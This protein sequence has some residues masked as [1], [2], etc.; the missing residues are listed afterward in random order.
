MNKLI[1]NNGE[2]LDAIK[3]VEKVA[4]E[5]QKQS[6]RQ[7]KFSIIVSTIT[8]CVAIAAIVVAICG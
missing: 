4:K 8:L 5:M 3:A 2:Q 1:T 6:D 7:W